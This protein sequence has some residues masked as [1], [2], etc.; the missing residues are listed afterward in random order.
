MRKICADPIWITCNERQ[1]FRFSVSANEKIRQWRSSNACL[2]LSPQAGQVQGESFG[3]GNR[4]G[5]RNASSGFPVLPTQRE[6]ARGFSTTLDALMR[7]PFVV[8]ADWFQYYDEPTHGRYDG[9]NFNFGLVDIH[10]RPYEALT[11]TAAAFDL[12]GLKKQRAVARPDASQGVPPAP[13]KPMAQFEP[14]LALKRWDRERGFVQ[15]FSAGSRP[16]TWRR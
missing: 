16:N 12:V 3:C 5:N 7:L 2:T 8:G 15:I 4:S 10:D 6:R 11:T 13:P 9:E 1:A 14:N